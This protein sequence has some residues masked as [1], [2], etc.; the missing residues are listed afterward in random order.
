ME[1]KAKARFVRM[2]PQKIRLVVDV[3]RGMKVEQAMR[4]L[5]FI[6]KAAAEPVFKLVQSAAA[7]AQHNFALDISTLFVKE[8]FADGG[9]VLHRWRPR[10]H[11]RAAAIRKR[12]THISIVLSDVA[13]LRNK[14]T[15]KRELKENVAQSEI[16]KEQK[17]EKTPK[18]VKKIRTK[19]TKK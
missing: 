1:V 15:V 8:I 14:K 16:Q 4:Q 6:N 7:N 12:T 19:P 18:T 2:S 3:V 10:A 11:G 13:P 5:K 9:P 17:S